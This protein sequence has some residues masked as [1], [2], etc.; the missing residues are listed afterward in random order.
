MVDVAAAVAVEH[1]ECV[2]PVDQLARRD[3]AR[4]AIVLGRLLGHPA[5]ASL[6]L[7][8]AGLLRGARRLQSAEC[9]I[10]SS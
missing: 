6:G 4:V 5:R 3:E 8:T 2:V 1:A 9:R 10:Q 7:V